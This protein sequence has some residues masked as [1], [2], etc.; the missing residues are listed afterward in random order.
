MAAAWKTAAWK[1][2]AWEGGAGDAAPGRVASAAGHATPQAPRRRARALPFACS[3]FCALLVAVGASG[4]DGGGADAAPVPLR[5][6][7]RNLYLGSDLAPLL[8]AL[9][10]ADIPPLARDVW[11]SVTASHFPDR[12]AVLA[13]EIARTKP[14]LV[15]L[16]EVSLYRT[17]APSNWTTG[18]APDAT[19][20]ALDF[21]QV[22]LDALAAAGQDYRTAAVG[23][24]ADA[25]LPTWDE[26]GTTYDLRLTD[27]DVLLVR[28]G[29]ATTAGPA[30]TFATYFS[31][32]IGGTGGATLDFHRGFITVDVATAGKS[33]RVG[34]S[35]LEVGGPLA[36]IQQAQAQEVVTAF[37]SYPAP[38]VLAGDFNSPADGSGTTSYSLLTGAHGGAPALHDAWTM[39]TQHPQSATD[40]PTCCMDIATSAS[41]PDQRIDL[42]LVRGNVSVAAMEVVSTQQ[43][44]S[45]VWP[46][47][48]LGAVATLDIR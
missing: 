35:H 1:T 16:Q 48:H 24:N 10:P 40:G 7:T 42:V 12:A 11:R 39:T 37:A 22:L 32:P 14:D 47:D 29:L 28:A 18:A 36:L 43:T 5:V 2:A 17:Q 34:N 26:A 38:I 46:S 15:A 4:C 44:A 41:A 45:G 27:R 9:S 19:D 30:A 6:M 8:G 23:W 20:V 13:D 31:I 25:E 3:F 21:L 33:I